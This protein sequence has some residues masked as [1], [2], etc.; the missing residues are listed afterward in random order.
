[1]RILENCVASWPMS[2]TEAQIN[3]LRQAF[4]ADTSKPFELKSS[5]PLGT[6]S[7]GF[8]PSPPSATQSQPQI[9]VQSQQAQYQQQQA[10]H[11][12]PHQQ[13]LMIPHTQ[14][15]NAHQ[16]NQMQHGSY[17][18]TPPVSAISGDSKPH[19]PSF[20]Q[21]YDPN[22]QQF[23]QIPSSN[24]FQH[25]SIAEQA[26]WN[27]TPIIDQFNTAFAIPASALAPPTSGYGSSP[28]G[29]RTISPTTYAGS[30]NSPIYPAPASY[31]PPRQMQ[32]QNQQAYYHQ[33]QQQHTQQQYV[34]TN[35]AAQMQQQMAQQAYQTPTSTGYVTPREWQQSVAAVYP[36]GALKRRWDMR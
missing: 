28:P 25:P 16:L 30:N 15:F 7:E 19:S 21:S 2:E 36:E 12:Q 14:S 26:Q 13:Q 6:P 10:T 9:P 5:F 3:G 34:D 1:M 24:Y 4:S 20:Q 8:Q 32:D 35:M 23:N 31:P 22:Q 17:L 27:P 33:Q 29:F 11:Q 18:A